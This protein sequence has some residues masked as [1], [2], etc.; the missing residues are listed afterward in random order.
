[1][2]TGLAVHYAAGLHSTHCDI[3][4]SNEIA[5]VF[6]INRYAKRR[7]LEQLAAAG[8][9]RIAQSGKA[10]PRVTIVLKRGRLSSAFEAP[11]PSGPRDV[12]QT[13]FRSRAEAVSSEV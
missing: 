4:V 3:P 12:S 11:R 6:G 7:A 10:A 13:A 2:A 5:E 8:L 9:I 1:L